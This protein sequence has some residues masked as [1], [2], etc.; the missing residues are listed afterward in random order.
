MPKEQRVIS[1]RGE[2]FA[3]SNEEWSLSIPEDQ[4]SVT[5]HIKL[6]SLS[7]YTMC[8]TIVEHFEERKRAFDY[9]E[10]EVIIP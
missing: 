6:S 5:F 10:H 3:D 7:A 2:E 8:K 4:K 1:V 9:Q